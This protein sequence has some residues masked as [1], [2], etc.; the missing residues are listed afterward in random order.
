MAIFGKPLRLWLRGLAAAVINSGAT[1]VTA[2]IVDPHTFADWDKLG[3]MAVVS[4]VLGAALYLKQHPLP[5][6]EDDRGGGE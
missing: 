2:L 6:E 5:A 4:A 1:T 3:K